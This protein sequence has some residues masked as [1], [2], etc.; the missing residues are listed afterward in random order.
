[1]KAIPADLA[2]QVCSVGIDVTATSRIAAIYHRSL[3]RRAVNQLGEAQRPELED[4][5]RQTRRLTP[6]AV[7]SVYKDAGSADLN[8]IKHQLLK[9]CAPAPA[10]VYT[11]MHEQ[12]WL[13]EGLQEVLRSLHWDEE[14]AATVATVLPP[15]VQRSLVLAR[16]ALR[17]SWP[18]AWSEHNTLV[19][20]LVFV[21]GPMRSATL[22][23][24]FGV[25]YAE[26]QEAGDPLRMF[27][28]LLHESAHHALALREQ[29]TR[30]I[31]NPDAVGTH[32]LRP[33]PRPLR[34]VLHAAF[35]M[36]RIAEGIRRYQHGH[37]H[38]GPLDGCPLDERRAF[39]LQSLRSALALLDEAARWTEDGAVLRTALKACAEHEEMQP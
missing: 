24:T 31:D 28:L 22:Q 37:P 2:E 9:A 18:E 8:D 3:A 23:S 33:D 35:V 32:A 19:E 25:I 10:A 26:L 13:R 14:N 11:G 39:A 1:M 20:Y 7:H 21:Q 16:Q 12:S 4:L 29:F 27:E 34:G 38:G 36:C 17:A 15:E 30:F 6:A 5:V